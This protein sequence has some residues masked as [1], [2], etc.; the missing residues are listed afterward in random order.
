MTSDTEKKLRILLV[1]DE[2]LI[3]ED[4]RSIINHQGYEVVEVV[5]SGERAIEKV[6][7]LQ[8]DLVLMD[9]L[10]AGEIDGIDAARQILQRSDIPII[11][12]TAHADQGT[13]ERAKK[14]Q[15]YGY[16]LKPFQDQEIQTVIE[17]AHYK[18]TIERRLRESENRFRSLVETAPGIIVWISTDG[19]IIEFNPEAERIL[20]RK[21]E[22]VIAH[23]FLDIFE[24]KTDE[25]K[26]NSELSKMLDGETTTRLEAPIR[27][28]MGEERYIMWSVNPVHDRNGRPQGVIAIGQDITDRKH[29]EELAVRH[30]NMVS[31]VRDI[32]QMMARQKNRQMMLAE[33]LDI[34][35][36]KTHYDFADIH[37]IDQSKAC[38]GESYTFNEIKNTTPSDVKN[39]LWR[40]RDKA[41]ANESTIVCDNDTGQPIHFNTQIKKRGKLLIIRRLAHHAQV[42]GILYAIVGPNVIIS[43]DELQLFDEVADD[44]AFTL[45][46]LDLDEK[47]QRAEE[48]V[49][50]S[51]IL[52]Q[53]LID[54]LPLNV[55]SKD[56]DGKVTFANQ[57]FCLTDKRHLKDIIGKTDFDLYPE[58]LAHKYLEDDKHVIASGEILETIEEHTPSDGESLTVRVIKAPLFDAKGQINGTLVIFWNSKPHSM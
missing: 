31:A 6:E 4:I 8:P 46:D 28:E 19:R 57:K 3:A 16:I 50:D 55:L 34:L 37:L 2:A 18:Y 40:C 5:P 7:K 36:K 35:I 45:Y 49:K 20:G 22:N 32:N 58:E 33:A 10:L 52:F 43:K 42:Y 17:T 14:T 38:V 41:L 53:S 54:S 27:T 51:Q 12:M 47:R 56:L 24:G 48:A 25:G 30:H 26:T 1:E 29:A 44:I 13:V 9:I 21:R 23:H 11:Y 15:P 39:G